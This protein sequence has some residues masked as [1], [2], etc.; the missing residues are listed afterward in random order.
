MAIPTFDVDM[1]IM[2]KLGDY[3][4]SD[5]GLT[6]QGFKEQFDLAG[7]LIQEYINSILLPGVNATIDVD[8]LV[9][10]AQKK[11]ETVFTV[12]MGKYFVKV[13]QMEDCVLSSGNRFNAVKLSNTAVRV[14]GGYAVIQ[15]HLVTLNMDEPEEITVAAGTYGTYRNDLICLRFTRTE[16]STEAVNIV[17][18]T[19]QTSQSA[20]VDPAY[21][22]EDINTA[23]P[24]VRDFPLYRI[25]L[26]NTSATL[27]PLFTSVDGVAD[28]VA[29]KVISKLSY[30][31]GGDY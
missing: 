20:G 26:Q 23:A 15:G 9:A 2:S 17:H 30:W 28:L 25:R 19:G 12:E 16:D 22:Q 27:E 1:N 6:P 10:A 24:A 7:K 4:G 11:L 21:M 14:Y 13:V 18:L 5:D 3:P 29:D 31:D 8:A